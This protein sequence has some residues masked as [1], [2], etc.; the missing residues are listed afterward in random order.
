M[1][2][3]DVGQ[4]LAGLAAI[5]VA[6]WGVVTFVSARRGKKDTNRITERFNEFQIM[7]GTIDTLRTNLGE[8]QKETDRL[9]NDLASARIETGKLRDEINVALANVAILSDHI[10]EHVPPDVPFPLLRRARNAN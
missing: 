6:V 8:A 4:F 10:R 7:E 5:F 3:A 9:R 2:G 1:S